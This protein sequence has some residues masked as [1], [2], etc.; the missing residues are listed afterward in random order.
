MIIKTYIEEICWIII[1]ILIGISWII[2][3]KNIYGDYEEKKCIEFYL[4]NN[5]VLDSCNKYKEKMEKIEK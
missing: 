2:W 3:T 5:Y 1:V 4:K